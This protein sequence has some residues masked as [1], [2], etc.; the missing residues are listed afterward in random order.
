M[1]LSRATPDP[2]CLQTARENLS[3]HTLAPSSRVMLEV[4]TRIPSMP[5]E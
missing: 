4:R 1:H 5:A 3:R 2:I